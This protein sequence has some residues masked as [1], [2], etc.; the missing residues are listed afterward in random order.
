MN[1]DS[2]VN[3]EIVFFILAAVNV[4]NIQNENEDILLNCD[5]IR[6]LCEVEGILHFRYPFLLN[7]CG[8]Y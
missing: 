3:A 8:E 6:E 4:I 5:H 7:R 2:I 1:V